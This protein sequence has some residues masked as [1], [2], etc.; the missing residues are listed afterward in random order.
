M[1]EEDLEDEILSR[2]NVFILGMIILEV[3][4]L[5]SSG[6]CYDDD[7]FDIFDKVIQERLDLVRELYPLKLAELLGLML[8]YDYMKRRSVE[9]LSIVVNEEVAT[10]RNKQEEIRSLRKS[11][12][13][14]KE[15]K[16]VGKIEG[17]KQNGV[18]GNCK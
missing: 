11:M 6:D 14:G 3:C 12:V 13:V 16:K 7:N 17:V 15:E 8:E 5:K 9:E 18:V 1:D 2:S 4:T 10:E